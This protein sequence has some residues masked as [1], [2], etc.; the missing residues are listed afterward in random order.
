VY[1]CGVCVFDVYPF[2]VCVCVCVCAC[3]VCASVFH[4]CFMCVCV[5][6]CVVVY[7]VF[8]FICCSDVMVLYVV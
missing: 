4:E 2:R 7:C 3:H 1:V 6:A 8:F 5:C